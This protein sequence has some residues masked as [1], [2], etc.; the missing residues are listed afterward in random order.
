LVGVALVLP[1][2]Q[3]LFTLNP[4]VAAIV[5]VL[6][7]GLLVYYSIHQA[8]L[9]AGLIWGALWGMGA[10]TAIFGVFHWYAF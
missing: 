8:G 3:L 1:L 10:L 5:M 4:W 9:V 2:L 7:G 6:L